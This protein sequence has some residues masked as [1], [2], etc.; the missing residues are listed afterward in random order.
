MTIGLNLN[1]GCN[2]KW[3]LG[4]KDRFLSTSKIPLNHILRSLWWK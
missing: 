2:L 4:D 3:K 1:Q